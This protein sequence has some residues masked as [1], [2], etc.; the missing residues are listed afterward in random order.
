MNVNKFPVGTELVHSRYG[1]CVVD[2]LQHP[3]ESTNFNGGWTLKIQN[4]EGNIQYAR[5]RGGAYPANP[6]P[7]LFEDNPKKLKSR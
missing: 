5:D 1:L 4:E 7:R 6:L 2:E 3:N